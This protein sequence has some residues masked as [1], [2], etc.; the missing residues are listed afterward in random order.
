[1]RIPPHAQRRNKLRRARATAHFPGPGRPIKRAERQK[2]TRATGQVGA[3]ALYRPSFDTTDANRRSCRDGLRAISPH[4]IGIITWLSARLISDITY[5]RTALEDCVQNCRNLCLRR[6]LQTR[7]KRQ[8]RSD[9][10][11]KQNARRNQVYCHASAC[12]SCRHCVSWECW[13]QSRAARRIPRKNGVDT[14]R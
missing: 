10:H 8:K 6:P 11:M 12:A 4:F 9:I 3:A 1:M 13:L 7:C 5:A 2:G 14:R